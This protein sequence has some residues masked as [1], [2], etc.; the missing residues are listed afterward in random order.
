MFRGKIMAK[1]DQS[2]REKKAEELRQQISKLR[3]RDKATAEKE[4]TGSDAPQTKSPRDFVNER[5]REIDEE[6]P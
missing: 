5:M 2:A 1:D 4:S 3:N 6:E